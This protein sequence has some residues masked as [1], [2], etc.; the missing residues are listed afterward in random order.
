[1]RFG[2]QPALKSSDIKGGDT[3]LAQSEDNDCVVRA[4]AAM[5]DCDYDKAHAYAELVLGRSNNR[6]VNF[7][8]LKSQIRKGGL[9]GKTLVEVDA[10][11]RYK[12]QGIVVERQMT[13]QT[14]FK[15]VPK[16]KTML[17]VIKGHIFCLKNGVVVGGN[18][19]D[20]IPTRKRI[21]SI[22]A[23]VDEEIKKDLEKVALEG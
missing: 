12:N 11:T 14:L 19:E 15:R 9:L 8:V 4:L 17:V 6:G 1:M 18:G 16:D 23:V 3:P 5:A 21:K 7:G 10:K 20:A 2:F 13:T 22:W